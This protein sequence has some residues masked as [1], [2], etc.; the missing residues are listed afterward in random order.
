MTT[1]PKRRWFRFW[2]L[3]LASLGIGVVATFLTPAW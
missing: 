1:T 2:I 3:S